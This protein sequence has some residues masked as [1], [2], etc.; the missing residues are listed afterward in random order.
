[1]PP[2]EVVRLFLV[3]RCDLSEID[4]Q[5]GDVVAFLRPAQ[6][7]MGAQSQRLRDKGVAVEWAESRLSEDDA[8][9]IDQFVDRFLCRWGLNG[10]GRDAGDADGFSLSR[11]VAYDLPIEGINLLVRFGDIVARLLE[12]YRPAQVI[13]DVENSATPHCYN[14]TNPTHCPRRSLLSQIAAQYGFSLSDLVP[15]DPLPSWCYE[16]SR[17]SFLPFLWSLVGGLR[18]AWL[19]GRIRLR[20]MRK[21]LVY[22]FYNWGLAHV[23]EALHKATEVAVAGDSVVHRAVLPLRYDHLIAWPN[24]GLRRAT[25]ALRSHLAQ[26][27]QHGFEQNLVQRGGIDYTALF[28]DMLDQQCGLKLTIGLLACAQMRAMLCRYRPRAC[29]VNGDGSFALRYLLAMGP[30][31]G[32]QVVFVDHGFGTLRLPY[33]AQAMNYPDIVMV[34][35]GQDAEAV[36][37][38]HMPAEQ[39]PKAVVLGNPAATAMLGV[40]PPRPMGKRLLL[41][42]YD[43]GGWN[44]VRRSHLLDRYTL[45]VF[46]VGAELAKQGWTVSYRR[47]PGEAGEYGP[48]ILRRMGLADVISLDRSPSLAQA[49]S[50]HDVVVTNISSAFYQALFAGWPAIFHE[51]FF[52]ASRFYGVPAAGDISPP[53]STSAETLQALLLAAVSQPGSAVARF[54]DRFRGELAERFIGPHP[55]QAHDRIA[56][57]VL[58]LAADRVSANGVQQAG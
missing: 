23:A 20:L 36:V 43:D 25:A 52:D 58:S 17:L 42:N 19:W 12:S 30:R 47:H 34:L 29:V 35:P 9:A 39:R 31:L 4:A 50:T 1:M 54:P 40:A 37:G 5:P 26:L 15:Q 24:K 32:T 2:R 51:P 48:S 49:L 27:R 57:F 46:T 56:G 13:T 11:A 38:P 55:E 22:V 21:P 7:P 45:D 53:V 14:D 16:V 33:T 18:P 44:S 6:D 3:E 41:L 10:D 8:V 28:L